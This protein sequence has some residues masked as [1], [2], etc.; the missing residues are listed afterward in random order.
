MNHPFIHEQ[1]KQLEYENQELRM[2]LE[3]NKSHYELQL[4]RRSAR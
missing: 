2:Q 1:I 4:R 3:H